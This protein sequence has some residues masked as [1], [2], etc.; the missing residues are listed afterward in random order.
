[1][2]ALVHSFVHSMRAGPAFMAFNALDF[3]SYD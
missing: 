2:L 1:M 3:V